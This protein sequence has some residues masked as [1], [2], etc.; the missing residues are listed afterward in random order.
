MNACRFL[1]PCLFIC[2]TATLPGATRIVAWNI[3]W[4]PGRQPIDVTAEMETAHTTLVQS[5]LGQMNPSLLL[6]SEIRDWR[7]FDRAVSQVPNLK[8]CVV[9]AFRD[10]D[11]GVLWTQQ[12]AI[13]SRLPVVAAWAES[14]RPTLTS[15][16]RGFALAVIEAPGQPDKVWLLYSVHLKSNRASNEHQAQLNYRLRNESVRQLL[17]H[18]EEMEQLVFRDR[19]AAIIVGGDFNTNHDNQFGDEVIHSMVRAG[20][21][22]TW[23]GVPRAERLTWRGSDQ[24]EPTTFDYIFTKGLPKLTAKMIEVPPEASDHHPVL[25]EIP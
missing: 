16:T 23:D 15:M 17:A 3:E 19:V 9:S 2:L 1:I 13:A 7:A 21:H 22:N 20:F 10:R 24:F 18:A 8:V 6:C 5:L 12:L 25:L 14:F 4:F 11:F